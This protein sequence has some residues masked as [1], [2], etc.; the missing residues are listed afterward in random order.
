MRHGRG[1]GKSQAEEVN[2]VPE[3]TWEEVQTHRRGKV[4]LLGRVRGVGVD[5]HR[6][7]PAP[8]HEHAWGLRGWGCS[9]QAIGGEK[10]KPLS[11]LGEI[12]HFLCRVPL[13]RH[14]LCGLR[15][16]RS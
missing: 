11:P 5:C 9:V 12:G 8:E 3:G 10:E 6:K 2:A 1:S 13:D 4:P 16:S 7:F 14:L 15:A